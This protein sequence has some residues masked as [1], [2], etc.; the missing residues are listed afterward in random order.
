[1]IR[2]LRRRQKRIVAAIKRRN[3]APPITPPTISP[4]GVFLVV[5]VASGILVA[6]ISRFIILE[7]EEELNLKEMDI[8]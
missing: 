1:M 4:N 2:A 7:N 3:A 6:F 8:K 5:L